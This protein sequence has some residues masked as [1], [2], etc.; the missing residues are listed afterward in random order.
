MPIPTQK[1]PFDLRRAYIKL[2]KNGSTIPPPLPHLIT[3]GDGGN[4]D[5]YDLI[6]LTVY[7]ERLGHVI[8][9]TQ[10]LLGGKIG[11]LNISK[12]QKKNFF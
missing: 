5:I 3:K 8:H 1:S 12:D 10:L 11:K 2:L 4:Y 9:V 6:H 7:T